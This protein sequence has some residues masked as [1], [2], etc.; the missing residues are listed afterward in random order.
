MCILLC[1]ASLNGKQL[2]TQIASIQHLRYLSWPAISFS[3]IACCCLLFS[4]PASPSSPSLFVFPVSPST[5]RGPSILSRNTP[6]PC[7]LHQ[8]RFIGLGIPESATCVLATTPVHPTPIP[9]THMNGVNNKADPV[10]GVSEAPQY[11]SRP[12]SLNSNQ[13]NVAFSDRPQRKV[14]IR[15]ERSLRAT[16]PDENPILGRETPA[17][18]LTILQCL[19]TVLFATK[20]NVLLVF[21]PIGI[22]AHAL[23]WPDVAVFILNFIAIV[24]LAKRK[25]QVHGTQYIRKGVWWSGIMSRSFVS[26]NPTF[27]PTHRASRRFGSCFSCCA[28]RAEC[29]IGPNS[30]SATVH[31]QNVATRPVFHPGVEP[32]AVGHFDPISLF[33]RNT[34][35]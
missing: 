24:P 26:R 5:P 14:T 32:C 30:H 35:S 31:P 28:T 18:K 22:V 12:A 27:L 11:S 2:I 9:I 19:K 1:I 21:I 25:Y 20:I 33:S 29:P 7:T 13:D 16:L 15:S 8:T 34:L 10:A 6:V 23:H 17:E 4:H 3:S